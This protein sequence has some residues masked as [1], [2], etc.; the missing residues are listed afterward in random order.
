MSFT[1]SMMDSE[2][3]CNLY[4]IAISAAYAALMMHSL[5][6][7]LVYSVLLCGGGKTSYKLVVAWTT[8]ADGRSGDNTRGQALRKVDVAQKHFDEAYLRL[9]FDLGRRSRAPG[10][11]TPMRRCRLSACLPLSL[12]QYRTTQKMLPSGCA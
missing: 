5:Q 8:D 11:P 6:T 12:S 3:F 7:R 9:Q 10:E 1:S 2:A 4:N